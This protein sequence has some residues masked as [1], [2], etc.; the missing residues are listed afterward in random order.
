M[1]PTAPQ[2]PGGTPESPGR[3]AGAGQRGHLGPSPSAQGL[4]GSS[5][6]PWWLCPQGA[7]SLPQWRPGQLAG[8]PRDGT[9]RGRGV[10]ALPGVPGVVWG[11][12]LPG[13][14]SAVAIAV[15]KARRAGQESW[16]G[17]AETS[18]H[19]AWRFGS[20]PAQPGW[21]CRLGLLGAPG[22]TS[23]S[24]ALILPQPSHQGPL[25]PSVRP[26]GAGAPSRGC[27]AVGRGLFG[28]LFQELME[29]PGS[30]QQGT[31]RCQGPSAPSTR[32][33]PRAGETGP[34]WGRGQKSGQLGPRVCFSAGTDPSLGVRPRG[35]QGNPQFQPPSVQG[36]PPVEGQSQPWARRAC[37]LSVGTSP[38]HPPGAQE[39]AVPTRKR[40]LCQG[41]P[42]GASLKP[43]TGSPQTGR[44]ASVPTAPLKGCR[45]RA[46]LKCS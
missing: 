35:P 12:A 5:S 36:S 38:Q 29:H 43:P 44:T 8:T 2:A 13:L 21:A 20:G 14:G 9:V 1:V 28:A 18:D 17:K 37:G 45:N 40:P 32:C 4:P 15:D 33:L 27:R 41:C 10:R 46:P 11:P 3:T 25:F 16:E 31:S 30:L 24:R 6:G 7:C 19:R 26:G 22:P 34:G 42:A 39:C 23:S